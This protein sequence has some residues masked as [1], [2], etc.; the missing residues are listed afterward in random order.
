M[1]DDGDAALVENLY[2]GPQ[3]DLKYTLQ[4]TDA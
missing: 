3:A 4:L 1:E 2:I